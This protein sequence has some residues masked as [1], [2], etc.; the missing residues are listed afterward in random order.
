VVTQE[1]I[2][3]NRTIRENIAYGR[4]N[5]TDAE[6]ERA[7]K[8]ANAH[9]FITK[10]EKGYDTWIGDRGVRMSGGQRQRLAIARAVAGLPEI[11]VLDEATSALDSES[12]KLVQEAIDRVTENT[13]SIIIAHRLSTVMHAHKIVVLEHGEIVAQGH[14]DQLLATC[15]LY[16]KLCR[17][18][19]RLSP[20]QNQA[21]K[22][23]DYPVLDPK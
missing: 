12:E 21:E 8:I 13:T 18:Q 20:D 6:V 23:T 2:L 10:M 9:E 22:V 5:L 14:H 4:P 11:L 17:L 19:F 3:F 1:S 15:P 16:Q 7:A